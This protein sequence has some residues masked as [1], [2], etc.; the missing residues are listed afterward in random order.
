MGSHH[1]VQNVWGHTKILFIQ[2]VRGHLCKTFG[3]TIY[4]VNFSL[5]PLISNTLLLWTLRIVWNVNSDPSMLPC[6]GTPFRLKGIRCISSQIRSCQLV[7]ILMA[8]DMNG[9]YS[10]QAG[11][12]LLH[13]TRKLV[14][15]K[16]SVC[17][18]GVTEPNSKIFFFLFLLYQI[19]LISYSI[20]SD[21]LW[22]T[23]RA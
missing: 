11:E 1:R 13:P 22:G 8:C 14:P 10:L 19:T 12:H 5:Y 18:L 17:K 4:L 2:S 6:F 16:L 21:H 23:L 3:W 9:T 15:C 7:L 20:T